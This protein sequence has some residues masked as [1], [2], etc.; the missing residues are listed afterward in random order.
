MFPC[1][2][3]K[4]GNSYPQLLAGVR[5]NVAS[6]TVNSGVPVAY[7]KWILYDGQG[8][9]VAEGSK[10][11]PV[12]G[13]AL[14]S[15]EELKLDFAMPQDGQ[16]Q[17]LVANESELPVWFDDIEIKHTQDLIVQEN[18]YDPWGL[19]LA[20][21]QK[22]G[23]HDD[24]WKFQGKEQVSDVGLNWSDFSARYYDP[25]LGRWHAV[26][27]A[28]QFSSPYL[29]MGNNPVLFTDPD[30]QFVPLVIG[31]AIGI[32]AVLNVASKRVF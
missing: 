15:W 8:N 9:P 20:G 2:G 5:A 13:A 28:D 32:G 19:E 6:A 1:T 31:A 23:T 21:I 26:D 24:K 25:Q 22:A 29:A 16:L 10:I 12:T 3:E 4:T 11:K 7:L 17:V 18:H 14:T 27:P 30:G